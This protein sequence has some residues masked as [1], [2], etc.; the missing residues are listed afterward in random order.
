MFTKKLFNNTLIKKT[1]NLGL[2]I[3]FIATS[4]LTWATSQATSNEPQVNHSVGQF[5]KSLTNSELSTEQLI[6]STAAN[7]RTLQH[8]GMQ[9]EQVTISRKTKAA[10]ALN[11]APKLLGRTQNQATTN[12]DVYYDFSIYTG[13]SELITDIDEDGYF[14]TFSVSFDADIQSSASQHQAMVYAD[15]YLSKNG[16]PWVL[17]FTTD[18]FLITGEN[19]EDE[20]EVVTQLESGYVPD[21]YDVLIDLYEVGYSDVVATYSSDDSNE[22]YALPLES[23]DYDPEYVEVIEVV[24]VHES[25]GGGVSWL[26]LTLL[27]VLI[28]RRRYVEL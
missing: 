20:F 22:L 5:K 13:Y 10:E 28:A 25:Y 1:V 26:L 4:Q 16:E 8:K 6:E 21:H 7:A 23:T 3:S 9:R 24:E 19:T 15:L 12:A 27:L 14:Q 17:Y 2:F 18:D 11:A